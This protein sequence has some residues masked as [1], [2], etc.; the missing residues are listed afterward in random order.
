MSDDII[1]SGERRK[2]HPVIDGGEENNCEYS[3]RVNRSMKFLYIILVIEHYDT[4][5]STFYYTIRIA[6]TAITIS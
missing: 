2:F 5:M 6:L 3:L 4:V 1:V